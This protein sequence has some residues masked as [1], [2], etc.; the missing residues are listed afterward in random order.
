MRN[1]PDFVVDLAIEQAMKSPCQSR[2][3]VVIWH[4]GRGGWVVSC[5]HNHKPTFA[6]QCT[7]DAA[8]KRTCRVEAVHAE[9][10][11]LIEALRSRDRVEGAEMLHV[12]V[13]Q[14]GIVPSGEPSCVQC[15]KLIVLAG[16]SGMWLFHE[17]G[18]KRYRAVEFYLMSIEGE[19]RRK[20]LAPEGSR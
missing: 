18:W 12:K 16:I 9:Q 19:S 10:H 11:A 17:D 3:G 20:P 1:P 15:A 6:N 7:R 2:R 13:E 4:E 5:G 14:G 8:C